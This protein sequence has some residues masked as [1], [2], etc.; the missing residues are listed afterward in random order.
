MVYLDANVFLFSL[1]YDPEEEP[2]AQRAREILTGV[3][4][5]RVRAFTSTLTWDEVVWVVWRL[6]GRPEALRV[7]ALLLR[8]P[9]LTFVD[10]THPVL[11]RAQEVMTTYGLRPRDSIHVASAL[12][13]GEREI[14]SDDAD[15]DRVDIITRVPL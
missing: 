10:V 2:K 3:A 7:G 8:F 13:V 9:N 1:L 5:G 15:L 11:A 6:V 4:H 12:A 14:V